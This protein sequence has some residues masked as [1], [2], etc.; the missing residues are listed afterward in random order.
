MTVELRDNAGLEPR[1]VLSGPAGRLCYDSGGWR[2]YL[3]HG[4]TARPTPLHCGDSVELFVEDDRCWVLARYEARLYGLEHPDRLGGAVVE[5]VTGREYLYL[6]GDQRVIL[7]PQ[8][9]ALRRPRCGEDVGRLH[10]ST[11]TTSPR[12]ARSSTSAPT[13]LATPKRATR[14]SSV[15]R[16]IYLASSW[17]NDR[18]PTYVEHLR[19]WGHAVYDFRNPER[20]DNGFGWSE[21]DPEWKSWDPPTFRRALDHPIAERGYG[22][23]L[24]GMRWANTFV[25]LLPCGS[26]AHFEAGWATGRGIPT[27]VVLEGDN[28]P[29]LMYKL[30]NEIKPASILLDIFELRD[31]LEELRRGV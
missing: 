22:N 1:I 23:D 8:H 7:D 9:T 6:G 20:G 29:E 27:A 5:M 11:S 30:A 10:N 21:I 19:S 31:W 26:S 17:R 13:G 4:P 15:D 18:Q 28:E 3:G 12:A 2:R 25:L 24:A 16:R 14:R